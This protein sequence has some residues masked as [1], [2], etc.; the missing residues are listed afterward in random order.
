M[1][2]AGRWRIV[3]RYCSRVYL[4]YL[5]GFWCHAVDDGSERVDVRNAV[6]DPIF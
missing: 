2:G 4:R 1:S 3:G 6:M 5:D